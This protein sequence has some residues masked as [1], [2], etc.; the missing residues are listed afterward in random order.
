[1]GVESFLVLGVG[2]VCRKR[3]DGGGER[4]E[5]EFTEPE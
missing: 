4:G 5:G 3:G 1:M 2:G